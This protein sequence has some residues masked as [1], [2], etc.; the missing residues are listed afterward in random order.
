[1]QADHSVDGLRRFGPIVPPGIETETETE[2]EIGTV[3]E[4]V[5][6]ADGRTVSIRNSSGCGVR[7]FFRVRGRTLFN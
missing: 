4:F 1:M 5:R 2:T 7:D 6:L 3:G